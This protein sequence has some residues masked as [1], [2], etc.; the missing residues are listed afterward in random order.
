MASRA[1]T[2]LALDQKIAE[3]RGTPAGFAFFVSLHDFVAYIESAPHF[4]VFFQGDRKG[5]RTKELSAKYAL[6]K[7]I[8]QGIE[9]L[10]VRTE[11]DLGHDRYV[12]IRDLTLIRNDRAADNNAFW[13]QREVLRKLAVEIHKTLSAYLAESEAGQ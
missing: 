4:S 5:S 6:M 11:K 1:A 9:D 3:V 2:R 10:A 8:H 13:K 12:A 7:Q